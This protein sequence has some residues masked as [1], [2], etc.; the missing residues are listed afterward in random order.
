MNQTQK[1]I[2]SIHLKKATGKLTF[3]KDEMKKEIFFK[4]GQPIYVDS[5]VRSEA[6]GQILLKEGRISEEQ[7]KSTLD[8][9]IKTGKRQGECLAELG[10]LSAYEI[11]QAL[12]TQMD[13]KFQNCLLIE[14]AESEFLEGEDFIREVPEFQIDV[15]H[16]MLDYF[17]LTLDSDRIQSLPLDVAYKMTPVG[18]TYLNNVKM[19]PQE[20]KI[21]RFLDGKTSL[22]DLLNRVDGDHDFTR[23]FITVLLGLKFVDKANLQKVSFS[24]PL[25]KPIEEKKAPKDAPKSVDESKKSVDKQNTSPIYMWAIKLGKPLQDM[26]DIKPRMTK[27]QI[28]RNFDKI[29]RELSLDQIEKQYQAKEREIAQSVLDRLSMALAVFTNDALIKL[30]MNSQAQKD[31]KEIPPKILSEVHIQKSKVFLLNKDFARTIVEIQKAIDI[32]AKEPSYFVMMSDCLLK[33]SAHENI[34]YPRA[35]V[36]NLKKAIELDPNYLDAFFELGTFYKMTKDMEKA[37]DYFSKCVDLNPNHAQANSELRLLNRRIA[38]N[39]K[40]SG[41]LFSGLFKSKKK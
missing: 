31:K 26:L 28:Q 38:E 27:A 20:S 2:F 37:R 21:V 11:Y 18:K 22:E 25:E 9:M 13:K 29:V 15:F 23:L 33:Q 4:K 3:I 40:A 24:K 36:D 16:V 19:L 30:Y 6:L 12:E 7:F 35:I 5:T 41:A 10:Y 8:L 17:A 39:K 32:D 14:D 1:T 34:E